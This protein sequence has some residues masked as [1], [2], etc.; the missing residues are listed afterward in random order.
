MCCDQ[1]IMEKLASVAQ[2]LSIHGLRCIYYSKR[3][4]QIVFWMLIFTASL[5]L[6]LFNVF[7]IVQLFLLSPVSV[8]IKVIYSYSFSYNCII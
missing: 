6:L 1:K 8:G 2:G 3:P 5:C 7:N 4:Y